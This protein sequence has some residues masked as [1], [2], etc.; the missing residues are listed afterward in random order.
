MEWPCVQL[1][2]REEQVVAIGIVFEASG[3]TQEMYDAIHNE[4]NPGNQLPPGLLFHTA[5]PSEGGFIVSEVWESQEAA[6]RFFEQQL[7]PA[8]QKVDWPGQPRF[9]QV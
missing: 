1:R 5:G 8:L 3:G 2:S 4:V 9:Y 7:G 6:Q